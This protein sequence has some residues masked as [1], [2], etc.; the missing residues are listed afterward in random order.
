VAKGGEQ[1]K[2]RLGTFVRKE[3]WA[4]RKGESLVGGFGAGIRTRQKKILLDA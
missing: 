3:R 1:V 2:K 4:N